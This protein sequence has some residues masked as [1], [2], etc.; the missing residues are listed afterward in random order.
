[1]EMTGVPAKKQTNLE[2]VVIRCG[3]KADVA[4]IATIHVASW[5]DTYARILDPKFLSDEIEACQFALWSARLCDR[6]VNQLVDVALGTSGR[7]L[8]FICCY[9]EFSP[10]W[11][12]LVDNLHVVAEARAQGIGEKLF[13]SVVGQLSETNSKLGL[14]L[15]VFEANEAG[16][17]FYKRLGGRVVEKR[18]AELPAARGKAVLRV[19]WATLSQIG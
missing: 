17:R 5:R 12:S 19:H 11:G 10:V 14:Y 18:G 13:R 9:R 6:G 4:Q 16:L 2:S 3:N 15:W 1:M 7:I 8:G